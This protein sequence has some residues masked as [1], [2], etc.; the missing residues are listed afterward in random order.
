MK[1]LSSPLALLL[2]AA[3]CLPVIATLDGCND[4]GAVPPVAGDA[5]ADVAASLTD[6]GGKM[7]VFADT[8]VTTP[9]P[10]G[11]GGMMMPPPD[12]GGMMMPPPGDGGMMMPPP[13]DGGMMGPRTCTTTADCTGACPPGSVGCTCGTSPMGQRCAPTCTTAADCP[14]DPMGTVFQCRTG[15]CV[16]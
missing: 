12:D 10:R 9:P 13:G 5:G 11:D 14:R 7:F 8:G 4:S 2:S 6:S 1:R 3:L 15:V 16:P